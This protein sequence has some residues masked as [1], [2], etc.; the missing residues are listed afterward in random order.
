MIHTVLQVFRGYSSYGAFFVMKFVLSLLFFLGAGLFMDVGLAA[1]A[2][3]QHAAVSEKKRE[4]G[5]SD[6]A[7]SSTTQPQP[8]PQPQRQSPSP[9]Q[10]GSESGAASTQAGQRGKRMSHEERRQLRQDI[11]EAG[12]ELYPPPAREQRQRH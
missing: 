2:S 6:V 4:P 5:P 7:P 3:A 9:A 8:Q 11:N 12:R 10:A 1:P